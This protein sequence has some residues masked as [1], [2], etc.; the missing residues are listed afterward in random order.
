LLALLPSCFSQ[1]ESEE[2]STA[3][4]ALALVVESTTAKRVVDDARGVFVVR[5]AQPQLA[6]SSMGLT[7]T[8][9]LTPSAARGFHRDGDALAPIPREGAAAGALPRLRVPLRASEP[10]EIRDAASPIAVRATLLGA[11]ETE[12]EV[13]DGFVV[14]PGA[15]GGADLIHRVREDGVEDYVRLDEPP[16]A[17][18]LRY[19]IELDEHVAGLRLVGSTLELLDAGAVPRL[20]VA[21][22]YLVD[23]A[24]EGRAASL[25]VEGCA[26]DTD[27]REPMARELTAPGARRCELVVR[28][29][30]EGLVYPILVDPSWTTTGSMATARTLHGAQ[31]LPNGR[32]LVVGGVTSGG[33]ITNTAEIYNPA[34]G[35][36]SATGSMV[37]T[38]Y[39]FGI[40]SVATGGV[41]YVLAAGGV[42]NCLNNYC[43]SAER[44]D[45]VMGTWSSAGTMFSARA[46]FP[47]AAL[48]DGTG[49]VLAPGG[50]K[51]SG[52]IADTEFYTA[53][54]NAW[55]QTAAL[56]AARRGHGAA[57]L[58]S[59]QSSR[60]VVVGG[61][62]PLGALLASAERYTP[63]AFSWS[64]AGSMVVGR[65]YHSTTLIGGNSVLVIGGRW[66]GGGT[67][68]FVRGERYNPTTNAWS[69]MAS[70]PSPGVCFH[71]ATRLDDG[72]VLV[73]GGMQTTA[74]P[75][76]NGSHTYDPSFDTWTTLPNLATARYG[77]TA[78]L[79]PTSVDSEVLIAGGSPG[80]LA[81]AEYYTP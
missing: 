63:S 47:L 52:V 33:L 7:T 65:A 39:Y 1:L 68:C 64:G 15:L 78:T 22:P 37:N 21:P 55:T 32:V 62:N 67:S 34:T 20:R 25:D 61:V 16:S 36:W 66:T 18:E 50:I 35:T 19:A 13:S 10:L 12:A 49:R 76:L 40:A 17:P 31:R 77:H 75:A 74:G 48:T 71:G 23:A 57:A 30:D 80:P 73:T 11:A 2:D 29:S 3:R 72:T 4:S 51:A 59:S 81:S 14:Y 56:T 5:R 46:D 45:V 44:Y 38:R 60:V 69:N 6:A 70:K 26:V 24:G 42:G 79:Y 9:M 53:S 27:P 58:S 8:P 28:W 43:A 41:T 54:T